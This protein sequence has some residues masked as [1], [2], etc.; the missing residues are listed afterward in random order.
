LRYG[1]PDFKLEKWILDRRID[2]LR[3][4]GV[5]FETEVEV[6]MDLSARYLRRSFQSVLLATGATVPRD[7]GLPGRDLDGIVFAMDFLAQQNRL[8]DGEQA[9]TEPSVNARD[10]QVVVLGGGDTGSD[11]VGTARRQAARSIT[12]I[13]I[14]P[15]PPENREPANPWPTWPNTMRTSSSHEEGCERIWSVSTQ[16]FLGESGRLR[17][18]RCVTLAWSDPDA[19]GRRTFSEVPGSAFE[20]PADLVLIAAGFLHVEHGPLVRDL[21]LDLDTRGNIRVDRGWNT[22]NPGVIAAGDSVSGASLVVNA[23]R[24]GR[25]AALA[26]NGILSSA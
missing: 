7:L 15:R 1:I 23:I 26:M 20:L 6:G 3:A 16:A 10:K 24:Q 21:G 8:V 2:Q 11:C 4:E 25:E 18:I 13:E 5:R 19:A 12:Q 22:S 17:A 9:G 14:L